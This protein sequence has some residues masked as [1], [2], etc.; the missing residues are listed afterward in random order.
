[1]HNPTD[2][3]AHRGGCLPKYTPRKIVNIR[4]HLARVA[5]SGKVGA[6]ISIDDLVDEGP[7]PAQQQGPTMQTSYIGR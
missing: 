7:R 6:N 2:K 5:A 3:P 1:M 4:E